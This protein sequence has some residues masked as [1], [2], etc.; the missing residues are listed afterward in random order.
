MK[1]K[2]IFFLLIATLS[3]PALSNYPAAGYV[4]STAWLNV[5]QVTGSDVARFSVSGGTL[6]GTTTFSIDY[7]VKGGKEQFATVLAAAS[8]GKKV[9]L[10]SWSGCPSADPS[11]NWGMRVGAIT[12][13]Y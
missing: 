9:F 5:V 12:I 13:Q 3:M 11:Q 1:S 2:F 10:E 8:A 7:P 6:C 4:A